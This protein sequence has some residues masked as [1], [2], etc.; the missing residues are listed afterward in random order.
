MQLFLAL[1]FGK[2][3]VLQKTRQTALVWPENFRQETGRAEPGLRSNGP[4]LAAL[5]LVVY[6]RK[7]RPQ[8]TGDD[9]WF[10][11]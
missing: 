5:K 6:V 8:R 3:R 1:I 4:C 7:F 9:S 11:K 10:H 2:K